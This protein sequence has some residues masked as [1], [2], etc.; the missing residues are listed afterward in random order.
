MT[1]SHLWTE[2]GIN[3]QMKNR[4]GG[5]ISVGCIFGVGKAGR[6]SPDPNHDL[7]TASKA[8]L[9]NKTRLSLSLSLRFACRKGSPV[10]GREPARN[11]RN[12]EQSVKNKLGYSVQNFTNSSIS[13]IQWSASVATFFQSSQRFYSRKLLKFACPIHCWASH[14]SSSNRLPVQHSTYPAFRWKA[15]NV[16]SKFPLLRCAGLSPQQI[17]RVCDRNVLVK[18]RLRYF[19][20]VVNPVVLF[21]SGHRAFHQNNPHQ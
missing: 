2:T 19:D 12:F 15:H 1:P 16:A 14:G 8:F 6:T 10:L 3:L 7:E 13:I 17:R 4:S 5:H 18:S 20:A 11:V 21:G 9:A